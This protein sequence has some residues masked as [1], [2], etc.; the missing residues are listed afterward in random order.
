VHLTCQNSKEGIPLVQKK[1][2]REAKSV[3]ACF[4]SS[5]DADG[6]KKC[7]RESKVSSVSLGFLLLSCSSL[8]ISIRYQLGFSGCPEVVA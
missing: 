2:G 4:M 7:R 5:R 1:K 8:S 6:S 3:P